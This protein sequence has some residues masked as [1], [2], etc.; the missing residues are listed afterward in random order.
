MGSDILLPVTDDNSAEEVPTVTAATIPLKRYLVGYG[1]G[2][3]AALFLFVDAH[4]LRLLTLKHL[5]REVEGKIVDYGSGLIG[6]RA[7]VE[8]AVVVGVAG[9]LFFW[10]FLFRAWSA[11]SR[12][13]AQDP[14]RGLGRFL[15][16]FCIPIFNIIWFFRVTWGFTSS[17]NG[18]IDRQ[19]T[20][21]RRM[22]HGWWIAAYSIGVVIVVLSQ[23]GLRRREW[24]ILF[25]PMFAQGVLH[26]LIMVRI[27]TLL[28]TL[29]LG[30]SS[31]GDGGAG[32]PRRDRPRR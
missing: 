8:L 23:V 16:C 27:A 13:K 14:A 30:P 21:G 24:P 10:V 25:T 17:Y 12:A 22:S 29:D 19:R 5:E 31:S 3:A 11:L 9:F 18:L 2:V 7:E 4:E 15:L 32:L 6:R 1:L 20:T 28:N 26:A